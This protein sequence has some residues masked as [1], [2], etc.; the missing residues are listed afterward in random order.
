MIT[1]INH[2]LD[3]VKR[4]HDLFKNSL[5]MIASENITSNTVRKLLASDLSHRYAEGKVGKRF[6]QGC[7]F[8]DR[9]EESAIHHAKELFRAEYVNVQPISGV[10]ANMAVFFALTEP[11]D[12][13]IALSLPH[14]GHVSH[15]KYSAAG[16]R[17]LVVETH[18][19]D[20][21]EMNI[22]PDKMVKKIRKTKPKIVMF[23]ASLF[24]FPHP[25][26]E[27]VDAVNEVGAK[28][29]YDG[30]HVLGLIAGGCFQDPLRE[31]ADVLTGSTHKTFPGPQGA[32]ILCKKELGEE[33]DQAVFPGTVSNHHLHHVA[34]L[35]VTLIEMREFGE[36]YARQVVKNA[37]ALAQ[38]LYERGFHVLCEEKGFTRSHQIAVDV[39]THGGGALV[40]SNLE[41]ANIIANKNMLPWD[42]EGP[43][44]PSGIRFGVQELTRIG[45]KEAEMKEI[46]D[47]IER[48]VLKEEDAGKVKKDVIEFRKEYQKVHYCFDGDGAYEFPV[49]GGGIAKE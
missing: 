27:A 5:P 15:A 40:A 11:G 24:L 47:F 14:G 49:E 4:H 42:T 1:E 7:A 36:E 45:M 32:I 41:R 6:Y 22:D 23:G 25:V 9:I 43:E 18:P 17:K 31:G 3:A 10:N 21:K 48:V 29:V 19:F 28:I 34:A 8:I 44:N 35:A 16:I 37:H 46:A 13:M 38:A 2:V 33:I 30:A 39:S 12:R 20:E 26:R